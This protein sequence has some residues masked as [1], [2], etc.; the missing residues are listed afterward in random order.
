MLRA[1]TMTL[2]FLLSS[3]SLASTF[4][5]G[6]VE[7]ATTD[8][9]S[10]QASLYPQGNMFDEGYLQVSKMHRIYYAQFGNPKGVPALYL[11]GGPMAGNSS[12]STQYFDPEYYRIIMFDQRGAGKSEPQGVITDN[13]TQDLIED[14]AKLKA[15]LKIDQ[16]LVTGG[17]W[18]SALAMAYGQAYPDHVKGFILRGIFDGSKQARMHLIYG[19]GQTYPQAYHE[20]VSFLPKHERDDLLNSYY[21]RVMDNDPK[22]HMPAAKAFVKYDTICG[23]LN[24]TKEAIDES[25]ADDGFVLAISRGFLHYSVNGFFM[26]EKQIIHNMHKIAHLP[27]IIVHGQHDTICPAQN[28]FEVYQAWPKSSLLFVQDAGHFSTEPGISFGLAAASDA[29]KKTLS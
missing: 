1:F 14:I 19:M 21:Q 28:A 2:L 26:Q 15:H 18:G 20:F 29:F 13:T 25:L 24:P 8:E 3:I 17:S 23:M 16:W 10:K 4:T 5:P 6:K 27:A 11:H 9:L 7:Y 12:K 22:I